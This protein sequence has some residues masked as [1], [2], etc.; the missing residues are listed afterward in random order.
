M[1]RAT[2]AMSILP[3]ILQSLVVQRIAHDAMLA[4]AI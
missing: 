1:W 2:A 3:I 4:G